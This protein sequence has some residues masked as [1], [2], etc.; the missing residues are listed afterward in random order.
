MARSNR[1]RFLAILQSSKIEYWPGWCSVHGTPP[2]RSSV[3]A[4]PVRS[5]TDT[6]PYLLHPR[7]NKRQDKKVEDWAK[8]VGDSKQET[9]PLTGEH[10]KVCNR[11]GVKNTYFGKLTRPNSQCI[12]LTLVW[13]FPSY[14]NSISV[15]V[16][17]WCET[18]PLPVN[19]GENIKYRAGHW[20]C[21]NFP[22]LFLL[23]LFE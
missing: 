15:S 14:Y 13:F 17:G 2:F 19:H 5:W 3:Q 18:S 6:H 21:Y 11:V 12:N 9:S 7:Q 23:F 8:C 1:A 16:Y 20:D 22:F 4:G 10:E